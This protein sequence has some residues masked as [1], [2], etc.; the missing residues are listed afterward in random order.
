VSATRTVFVGML[1]LALLDT[2]ISSQG[3]ANR[4]GALFTSVSA[5]ISH[6]L[7][8]TVPAIPDLR[9]HGGA[10]APSTDAAPATPTAPSLLPTE[11]TTSPAVASPT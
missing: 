3:A 4:T 10:S 1:G 5:V 2:A 6:L 9:K 8:P 7:S 11:W